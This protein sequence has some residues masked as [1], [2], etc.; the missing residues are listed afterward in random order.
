MYTR[1]NDLVRVEGRRRLNMLCLGRG[2]PTVMMINGGDS[3]IM[4]WRK[5]QP[6]IAAFTRVCAFDKAGFGHSDPANRPLT[7]A[8][9]ADDLRRLIDAA[10]IQK[11]VVL[12]GASLGGEVAVVFA[13][14]YTKSVAGLV[15]SDPTFPGQVEGATAALTPAERAERAE[16]ERK[17]DATGKECLRLARA[18][19]L[20]R[21]TD[22][23][24]CLDND[25]PD[26][27]VLQKE[28]DRQNMRPQTQ[29]ASLTDGKGFSED[30]EAIAVTSF[31]ALPLIV[32]TRGR[33]DPDDAACAASNCAA[34]G[35]NWRA[36]HDRLAR[37]STIGQSRVVP[38]SGHA[39]GQDRPEAL[40][41]AVREIV[42]ADL[43]ASTPK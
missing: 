15:L 19:K 18:A 43:K 28:L 1:P 26:D 39:I 40:A 2:A 11:P 41:G 34:L 30:P 32:L 8:N 37:L 31:G 35:A 22:K 12:V 4:T 13:S 23:L 6:M 20:K 9:Q 7:I 16:A 14:R 33:K 3:N 17:F 42:Q 36:G 10:R 5:V 38:N 29:S 24:G 27:P 25:Y 21:S